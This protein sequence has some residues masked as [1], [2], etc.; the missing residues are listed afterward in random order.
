MPPAPPAP[1][2]VVLGWG[3]GWAGRQ[4]G[5]GG[6][7]RCAAFGGAPSGGRAAGCRG[8][9]AESRKL[10]TRATKRKRGKLRLQLSRSRRVSL[11]RTMLA[12]QRSH[13]SKSSD[14]SV[15]PPA[16]LAPQPRLLPSPHSTQAVA[17]GHNG[18]R[19][20]GQAAVRRQ[21]GL[22]RFQGGRMMPSRHHQGNAGGCDATMPP[23]LWSTRCQ[24][25]WFGFTQRGQGGGRETS[26]R[27]GLA[28]PSHPP[29]PASRRPA[30]PAQRTCFHRSLRSETCLPARP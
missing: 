16:R 23:R 29:S 25:R 4:A 10:A 26:R 7:W 24:V 3:G 18:G 30:S 27:R 22:L 1:A 9:G 21:R 2:V 19:R 28:P 12:L 8:R 11:L 6:W 15:R 14:R 5:A 20:F 17:R 13:I